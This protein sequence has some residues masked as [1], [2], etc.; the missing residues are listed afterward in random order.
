MGTIIPFPNPYEENI[1]SLPANEL[2]Q[3]LDFFR[4]QVE[5]LDLDEPADTESEEYEQW[6]EAHED[7]ED[8]VDE[9][10]D[11]LEDMN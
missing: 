3:L 4:K 8:Q 2:H 5:L 10:L 6:G 7:L 11:L 9:I 1:Y